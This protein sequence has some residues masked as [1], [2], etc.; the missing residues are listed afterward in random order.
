MHATGGIE[1]ALLY[2]SP[3]ARDRRHRRC[4]A[5]S[6]ALQCSS[7]D[8]RE[9]RH[10]SCDAASPALLCSSPESP[11]A[12]GMRHRSPSVDLVEPVE[13]DDAEASM[14]RGCLLWRR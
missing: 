12:L 2:S 13:L 11:D 1:A 4:Y 3:D 10:R 14:Q 9:M 7:P 6:P 5:T 8:A